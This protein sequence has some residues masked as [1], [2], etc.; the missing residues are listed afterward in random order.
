MSKNL[1]SGTMKKILIWQ[2]D[3]HF[4]M[5]PTA[6]KNSFLAGN[7][8][9]LVLL[10][11]QSKHDSNLTGVQQKCIGTGFCCKNIYWLTKIVQLTE[12]EFLQYRVR[13][14]R[15]NVID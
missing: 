11:F 9:S 3:F 12:L 2:Y 7:V 8:L 10:V 13:V 6:S 15:V 4:S 1:N 5:F 14:F